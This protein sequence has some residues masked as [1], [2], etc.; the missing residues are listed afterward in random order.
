MNDKPTNE[1]IVEKVLPIHPAVY[2]DIAIKNRRKWIIQALEAKDARLSALEAKLEEVERE[3]DVYKFAF[4]LKGIEHDQFH[5]SAEK[6]N[7]IISD[8]KAKLEAAE[9]EIETLKKLKGSLE[10]SLDQALK[11]GDGSYRP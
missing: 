7:K 8:L 1:E 5:E 2:D 6:S 3:R 10:R 11:E 9:K 4:A